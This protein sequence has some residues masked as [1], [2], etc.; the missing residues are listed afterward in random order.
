MNIEV[1]HNVVSRLSVKREN[2]GMGTGMPM[3]NGNLLQM[4]EESAYDLFLVIF[5]KIGK[6]E[7]PGNKRGLWRNKPEKLKKFY[8]KYL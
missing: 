1:Q 8:I 2:R 5:G 6:W 7:S 4:T 3:R